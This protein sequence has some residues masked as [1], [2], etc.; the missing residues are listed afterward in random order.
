MKQSVEVFTN[1]ILLCLLILAL[2]AELAVAWDTSTTSSSEG[3]IRSCATNTWDDILKDGFVY[4]AGTAETWIRAFSFGFGAHMLVYIFRNTNATYDDL[5]VRFNVSVVCGVAMGCFV[6]GS[7]LLLPSYLRQQ[8]FE[9]EE[10][11][12]FKRY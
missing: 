9:Y 8:W 7:S 2:I 3:E 10:R 4:L 11:P 12:T 5:K 6:F 1:S